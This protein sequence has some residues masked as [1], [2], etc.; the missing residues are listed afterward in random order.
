MDIQRWEV[1]ITELHVL[2]PREVKLEWSNCKALKDCE[3]TH[4]WQIPFKRINWILLYIFLF[5]YFLKIEILASLPK[6]ALKVWSQ[7]ILLPQLEL[8]AYFVTFG[9][10]FYVI[11]FKATQSHKGVCLQPG[12]VHKSYCYSLTEAQNAETGR[13]TES[14]QQYSRLQCQGGWEG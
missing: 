8:Q 9:K 14:R 5:L 3:H 7:S 2:W 1:I 13:G 10:Q 4:D 12:L 6:L 11:N